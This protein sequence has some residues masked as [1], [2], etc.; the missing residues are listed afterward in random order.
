M[1]NKLYARIKPLMVDKAAPEDTG[2]LRVYTAKVNLPLHCVF[3]YL[4]TT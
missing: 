1:Y 4:S 3:S 2:H